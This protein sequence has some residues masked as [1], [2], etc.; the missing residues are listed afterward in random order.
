MARQQ[1]ERFDST[2]ETI[3]D[4]RWMRG[5]DGDARAGLTPVRG[6][7]PGV[8]RPIRRGY[9]M[10]VDV[11]FRD[12]CFPAALEDPDPNLRRDCGCVC[13]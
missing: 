10:G 4:L 3:V 7:A 6:I 13:S 5:C 1:G 2:M 8:R 11:V 12:Q 9:G